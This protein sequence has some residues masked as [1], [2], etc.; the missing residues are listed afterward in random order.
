MS[1]KT[2]AGADS[3][4]VLYT[5]LE[6]LRL[7]GNDYTVGE[8]LPLAEHVAAPLLAA[9]VLAQPAADLTVSAD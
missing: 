7:D 1:K 8:S 4:P 2:P 9:N 6:P 5:V 3:A